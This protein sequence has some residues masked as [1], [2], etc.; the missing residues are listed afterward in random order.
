VRDNA[1]RHELKHSDWRPVSP[2][3]PID[4]SIPKFL[5]RA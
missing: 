1:E 3:Q 5:V 2:A 4:L